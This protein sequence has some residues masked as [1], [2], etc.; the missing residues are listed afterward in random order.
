MPGGTRAGALKRWAK[1]GHRELIRARLSAYAQNR[2][3]AHRRAL[4]AAISRTMQ[5][6]GGP[7]RGRHWSSEQ[8]AHLALMT[9]RYLS[10]RPYRNQ[11]T[12]LDRALYRMLTEAGYSFI[13]QHQ[14]GPYVV[15][16]Y[17]PTRNIAWE[18][19]SAYWHELRERQR[20]GFDQRR[21]QSLMVNY[22]VAAV[23]VL[24]EQDLAP[25]IER[26]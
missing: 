20:P 2:T 10:R 17:D 6:T 12:R 24:S 4:G 5:R 25:W 19:Y 8:R 1:P 11:V 9:A 22:G 18:A 7:W 21:I 13:E 3:P 16:A 15:D 14:I 23:I 26:G